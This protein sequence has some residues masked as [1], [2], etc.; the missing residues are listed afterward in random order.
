MKF[1]INGETNYSNYQNSQ[2]NNKSVTQINRV[3]CNY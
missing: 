3:L 1:G 2:I